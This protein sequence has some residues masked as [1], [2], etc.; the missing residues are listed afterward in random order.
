[1][2]SPESSLLEDVDPG[3]GLRADFG[4][5]GQDLSVD[6]AGPGPDPGLDFYPLTSLPSS[7]GGFLRLSRPCLYVFPAGR[8]DSA[9][10]GVSGFSVLVNGGDQRESCFWRLVRHL[11]RVDAVLL[12]HIGTDNLPGVNGFLQR[13]LEE[14][15]LEQELSQDQDQI[16]DQDQV[17]EWI[18]NL[19]S[20]EVSKTCSDPS[21]LF[22]SL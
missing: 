3:P 19:V 18:S 1:M 5:S 12:T 15:R 8:G 22:R 10:F 17:Q 4:P 16:P 13:K 7:C 14:K 11:D 2:A 21:N 20:P 9:L 6:S